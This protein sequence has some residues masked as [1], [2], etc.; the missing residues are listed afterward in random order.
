M[1]RE[2]CGHTKMALGTENGDFRRRVPVTSGTTRG[3]MHQGRSTV[4]SGVRFT[5]L[6]LIARAFVTVERGI[7]IGRIADDVAARFLF[8]LDLARD[9]FTLLLEHFHEHEVRRS[10][11]V[12]LVATVTLDQIRKVLGNTL[13]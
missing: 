4:V 3:A 1:T 8:H 11:V 12:V 9:N 7:R 6:H 13:T 2:S 5:Q 10:A